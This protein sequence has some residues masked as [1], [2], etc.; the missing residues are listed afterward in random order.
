M[1][2]IDCESLVPDRA[3]EIPFGRMLPSSDPAGFEFSGALVP[4]A[5]LVRAAGG[6]AC[7]WLDPSSTDLA[8]AAVL[9]LPDAEQQ[10]SAYA[11]ATGEWGTFDWC[12]RE[13]PVEC[14]TSTNVRGTWIDAVAWGA[15]STEGAVA[16]TNMVANSAFQ[17][18]AAGARWSG[19]GQPR[20]DCDDVV[21]SDTASSSLDLDV[22][23]YIDQVGASI[24]ATA[25]DLVGFTECTVTHRS[26]EVARIGV[27]PGAEEWVENSIGT[28]IPSDPIA[29][30]GAGFATMYCDTLQCTLD[31]GVGGDWLR[32]R[33]STER[34]DARAIAVALVSAAAR[35]S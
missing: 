25:G 15:E 18:S 19:N 16:L 4:D 2:D 20:R 5:I 24:G 34:D 32:I 9:M 12:Y 3:F 7:G 6:A 1:I 8:A 35:G 11:D 30:E 31:A 17:A 29:I 27:L 28:W 21:N 13:D 23:V 22:D 33:V 14:G 10:W 26:T